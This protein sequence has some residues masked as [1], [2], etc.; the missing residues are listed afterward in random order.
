M[1]SQGSTGAVI[2]CRVSTLEQAEEGISLD[3]QE[4]C[5]RKYCISREYHIHGVFIERGE[6]GRTMNRPALQEMLTF[7]RRRRRGIDTVVVYK[8]DRLCRNK[9]S[10]FALQVHLRKYGI[11][12]QSTTEP[13]NDDSPI[14]RLLEGILASVSEFESDLVSQRTKLSMQHA[15][16]SGRIVH[17]PPLGYLMEKREKAQSQVIQDPLRAPLIRTAFQLIAS[18][19]YTQTEVRGHLS[20]KGLLTQ[21]GAVLTSQ[22]FSRML[23]NRTYAGWIYV[24]E[25]VGY[26]RGRFDP[27]VTDETFESVQFVLRR[28][29]S[30]KRKLLRKHPDFP[31]RWFMKCG[32]CGLPLTGCWSQGRSQK[33]PYYRCRSRTCSFGNVRKEHL[34]GAFLEFLTLLKPSASEALDFRRTLLSAWGEQ[35]ARRGRSIQ[36]LTESARGLKTK[37][38]QLRQAFIYDSIIDRDVFEDESTKL[39]EEMLE[40]SAAIDLL[41][42]TPESITRLVDRAV[43]VLLVCDTRWRAGDITVKSRVQAA[44]FPDGVCYS[45]T[46]GVR[47]AL[48]SNPFNMYSALS[49]SKCRMATPTGIEPVLPA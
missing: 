13:L 23:V 11:M 33:Y 5:C 14:T 6:S 22:S 41:E 9:N 29:D 26:V 25:E 27:I 19:R 32:V 47:T 17:R 2:Y 4:A 8:I 15:R 45:K 16:A 44:L 21:R 34:E 35:V 18:G 20:S 24:S 10:Y 1:N 37:Q 40:I 31:L 38:R 43:K 3:A 12:I 42:R 7:C 48:S 36:S 28:G 46:G 39:A 30:G 49:T